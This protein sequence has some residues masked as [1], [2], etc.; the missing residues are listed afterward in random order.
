MLWDIWDRF[1]VLIVVGGAILVLA[2]VAFLIL[3][4]GDDDAADGAA[5]L[6]E[7]LPA[8]VTNATYVDLDGLRDQLG[9]AADADPTQVSTDPEKPP[10]PEQATFTAGAG[11]A[12]QGLAS[13]VEDDPVGEA[14]DGGQINSAIAGTAV[15]EGTAG[16]VTLID[17]DQSFD[18][19]ASSLEQNGFDRDGA[20]L[21]AGE[22]DNSKPGLPVPPAL[23]VVADAGDGVVAF[24][25]SRELAESAGGDDASPVAGL[26][27]EV[28]G[29]QRS[30]AVME[31]ADC[32]VETASG[33]NADP[34]EGELVITLDEEANEKNLIDSDQ[35]AALGIEVSEPVLTGERIS[36]TFSRTGEG[37]EV[38]LGSLPPIPPATSIY[39]CEGA[40]TLPEV[41]PQ[42]EPDAKPESGK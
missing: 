4:G 25:S 36:L 31:G 42:P 33:L 37:D 7:K 23:N 11:I 18:D 41:A 34:A 29:V 9:L 20:V 12:I 32:I 15:E 17:T 8:S 27:G 40:P 13:G 3:G 38:A 26:L 14:V 39:H 1:R 2:V 16:P 28:D 10:E 30:A 24:S 35:T 6:A 22:P 5:D 19:I 21:E